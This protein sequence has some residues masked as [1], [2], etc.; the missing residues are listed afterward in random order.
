MQV[1][2]IATFLSFSILQTKNSLKNYYQ[3]M[4]ETAFG[5]SSSLIIDKN[6]TGNILFT[7][8]NTRLYYP[9]NYIDKDLI[10]KC[11]YNNDLNGESNSQNICLDQYEINQIISNQDFIKDNAKFECKNIAIPSGSRNPF[12][13]DTLYKQYCNRKFLSK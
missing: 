10:K 6:K 13:R 3:N 1:C 7:S 4:S 11:I 2:I 9:D 5:F 8:R 12:N